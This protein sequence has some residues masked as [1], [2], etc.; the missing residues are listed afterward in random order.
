MGLLDDILDW[1]GGLPSWQRDALR[2]LFLNGS[3]SPADQ[4]ELVALIEEEHG[5]GPRAA[6]RPEPLS[7]DHIPAA[8]SGGSVHLLRLEN[9]QSVN[10][11][12][13]GR[14]LEL[15]PD[16][17]NVLFGENG[18]GKSGYARVLRNACRARQRQPV[19]PDAFDDTKPRP[20]PSAEITFTENGN[21]R[22]VTWSQ[23]GQ[24]EP[25]LGRVAV[26]D[27]ACGADYVAKEGASNYQ[28]FGLPHLHRLASAQRE[29]QGLFDRERGQIRLNAANFT[30]LRGD[31]DVGWFIASLSATSDIALLRRLGT[32]TPDEHKRIEE[33]ASVLGTMNPEPDA[34]NAE[35]LA[36]RLESAATAAQT[37][38][39][40]VTERALD[41]V[42]QRKQNEKTAQE[43]WALAQQ[44]LH[45]GNDDTNP[46]LLP[47]TGN[48]VW[49]VLFEAAE[50]FSIEHAYPDHD[51][52]NIAEGAK[53]VLCQSPLDSDAKRRMQRFAEYVAD[54][55]S[56][57]AHDTAKRMT[58]TMQSIGAA[59]L[60]PIDAP[61]LEELAT[62]DPELHAFAI[63]TT[64]SW[65]ERRQWIR[66]AIESGDWTVARPPMPEGD[67]LDS[68]LRTKAEELRAHAQNLRSAL[69]PA[70]K[71]QLESERAALD[72]RNRLSARL[73][74]VEQ[75]V[76]DAK[77]HRELTACY[78]AL[79]PRRVSTKMTELAGV[80][81]TS[82]LADATN[83]ELRA[84]GYRRSVEPQISGRTDL[85]Q[86]MVT[87]KIKGCQDSAHQ[88]LS[89]GEQRAM[90]LALF[91][92]EV[93]LQDHA[94]TVVFDDPSTSLDHRHRRHMAERLAALAV[95]RP[96][97]VFTHDAVFLAEINH[98]VKASGQPV[99]YQT[100]AWGGASPG[101]VMQ[102]L[103]WE[104]MSCDA[105][106][107][108]LEH[109]AKTIAIGDGDY[110]DEETKE[111]VKTC[112][113]KLRGTIER[114]VR[115]IFLNNTV[116]PFSDEVS[117]DSFGAVVG[118]PQDEWQQV[119]D[120]YARCC[121]VTDA[122][123]TN[124]A[125]QLPI[126]APSVLLKDLNDFKDLLSK[127]NQRRKT[128]ETARGQKNKA[129]KTPFSV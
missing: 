15:A 79:N 97:L 106:L 56:Q 23:G 72:A 59:N 114:G 126:P 74:E 116:K 24:T 63:S 78:D 34:R 81:V 120:L 4:S 66:K 118:H 102:G 76:I 84:L 43:A 121:E 46:Q 98:A 128:Y 42:R 27:G 99:E 96:V 32:L 21:P 125:H 18:A 105:R 91:L 26:Y 129:R 54:E 60:S 90:G 93:R 35:R 85:G 38:Q 70:A 51:H 3:L 11:F 44:R 127:A 47:G 53:C 103:T 61:T 7:T 52:P 25:V 82:A 29:L 108:D 94:S 31:H 119:S 6:I 33:L 14:S 36:T 30:D 100:V 37:A 41:E 8:G 104:T 69:D 62:A 19:L 117:V 75:Y 95:E 22:R 112:Y 58:E 39:R 111:K 57:N 89:E 92:A 64:A 17:L 122:H 28:P 50:R 49:K 45:S 115:E 20:I 83:E 77:T 107:A 73:K 124:A 40:Y 10:R 86:T 13:A 67:A 123:D 12:A 110:M 80:Y 2:R 109:N 5:G 48:D 65:K 1:S 16:R 68:R 71:A 88:V 87:L 113:T 9:L 101:Y 55:A